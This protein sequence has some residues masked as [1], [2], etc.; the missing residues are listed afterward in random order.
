MRC[1]MRGWPPSST[2]RARVV[3]TLGAVVHSRR[4]PAGGSRRRRR[5]AGD[6]RRRRHRGRRHR[7]HRIHVGHDRRAQ[8]TMHFHRDLLAICDCWPRYVL[9]ATPDDVFIGTPPLA[10]TFGLGGLVL[11]PLRVAPATLL[12]EKASPDVL[13]AG[14]R[15]H[16]AT[17][18][19]TAPT[20]YRAMARGRAQTCLSL[21]NCVSAGEH[22][23]EGDARALEG[24]DRHRAD[25]RHRRD[26][27]DAHLHLARRHRCAARRDRARRSPGYSRARRWT[28]RPRLPRGQRG[29]ARGEG[30]DRLPLPRRRASARLRARRLEL[31]GDAYLVDE[32]GY[33]GFS[34]HR[35]HDRLVRL[36]H[37]RARGR[38]RR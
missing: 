34:A 3:P 19:F 12:L 22:L 21:R 1:A 20:A 4:T 36:Q 9:R 37:R 23:P 27:N 38:G 6:V 10:F 30:A 13:L 15:A 25:R 7:A 14:D 11:F 35:R 17:V 26:R 5:Q 18:L 31:T 32:D 16:R 29:P 33:F 8:G 2:R 28:N 24:R